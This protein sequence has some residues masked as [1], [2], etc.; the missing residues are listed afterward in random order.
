VRWLRARFTHNQRSSNVSRTPH[1]ADELR[2]LLFLPITDNFTKHNIPGLLY[3][4]DEGS[5]LLRKEGN[6]YQFIWRK[7]AAGLNLTLQ[8][9]HQRDVKRGSLHA[10]SGFRRDTDKLCA[11]LGCYAA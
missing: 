7:I 5:T 6:I 11:L 10:T 9:E 4:K 8:P 1:C 3:H 2:T